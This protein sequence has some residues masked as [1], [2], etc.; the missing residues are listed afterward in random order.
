MKKAI[1]GIGAVLLLGLVAFKL[2]AYLGYVGPASKEQ[3]GSEAIQAMEEYCALLANV[4][5]PKDV[6]QVES[7]EAALRERSLQKG[8][9]YSEQ[10]LQ[11]RSGSKATRDRFL[12]ISDRFQREI[13]RYDEL[14]N[15]KQPA[16][17]KL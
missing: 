2:A 9:Q 5:S 16:R 11:D 10:V 4:Q 15:R 1:A 17:P 13:K 8:R 6:K 14:A 3:L 12:E 7:Q